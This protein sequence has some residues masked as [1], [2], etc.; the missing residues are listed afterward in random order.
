M[1]STGNLVG[2][3]AITEMRNI[4]KGI[5]LGE[6]G[7]KKLIIYLINFHNHPPTFAY[8]SIYFYSLAIFA[9]IFKGPTVCTWVIPAWN[10]VRKVD[11]HFATM[12]QKLRGQSCTLR[13][14]QWEARRDLWH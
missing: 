13:I 3:I 12:K 2:H 9:G 14:A 7:W 4:R 10:E 11:S 1:I 8:N 5:N 6:G